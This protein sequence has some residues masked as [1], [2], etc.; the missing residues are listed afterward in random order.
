[1]PAV[2]RVGDNSAGHCFEPHP[3]LD[4]SPNVFVNGISAARVGSRFD[5]H[6]CGNSSH[7]AVQ[8]VGSSSV[9]VN[10]IAVA[11]IADAQDCGDVLAVGSP[12]VFAGG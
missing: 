3:V 7:S 11:R 9:F 6:T 5:T 10:G 2:S 4:G 1:M 12:N 8:A